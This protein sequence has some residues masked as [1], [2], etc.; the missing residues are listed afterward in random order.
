MFLLAFVVPLEGHCRGK[1]IAH[2]MSQSWRVIRLKGALSSISN[3]GIVV[4]DKDLCGW[5]WVYSWDLVSLTTNRDVDASVIISPAS[6]LTILKLPIP[7][8][9]VDLLSHIII[10]DLVFQ[11]LVGAQLTRCFGVLKVTSNVWVH[12]VN[13]LLGLPRAL[14]TALAIWECFLLR[15]GHAA[16]CSN[17]WRGFPS[18][19]LWHDALLEHSH[20]NHVV[21]DVFGMYLNCFGFFLQQCLLW[22]L[23]GESM[24]EILPPGSWLGPLTSGNPFLWQSLVC[25]KLNHFAF[26]LDQWLTWLSVTVCDVFNCR[27]DLANVCKVAYELGYDYLLSYTTDLV[28]ETWVHVIFHWSD[29]LICYLLS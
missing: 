5:S 26:P 9:N 4:L 21:K 20:L 17:L 14:M 23:T 13:W 22:R 19:G 27:L 15:G 11:W 3:N 6:L 18:H 10:K 2:K 28:D 8:D 29:C 7:N 16:I 24:L 12:T 25:W 1:V